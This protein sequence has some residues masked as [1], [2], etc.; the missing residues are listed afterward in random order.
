[1]TLLSAVVLGTDIFALPH[2]ALP[3]TGAF[4]L[5]CVQVNVRVLRAVCGAVE[6]EWHSLMNVKS[7]RKAWSLKYYIRV[8]CS[9]GGPRRHVTYFQPLFSC[10]LQQNK[11]CFQ[12]HTS[13]ICQKHKVCLQQRRAAQSTN[14][15]WG[16][17]IAEKLSR[18]S[19]GP[20]LVYLKEVGS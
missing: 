14:W 11:I 20:S 18:I 19:F 6:R 4:V 7:T 16:E 15:C 10:K 8:S 1:M 3:C 9:W 5:V 2:R 17:K 13:L 12:N